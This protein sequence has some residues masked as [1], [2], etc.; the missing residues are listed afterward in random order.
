MNDIWYSLPRIQKIWRNICGSQQRPIDGLSMEEVIWT[1]I[2]F[3]FANYTGQTFMEQ[4]QKVLKKFWNKVLRWPSS[5]SLKVPQIEE[6]NDSHNWSV[7]FSIQRSCRSIIISKPHWNKSGL[8]CTKWRIS[9]LK[10][11]LL[12]RLRWE[13]IAFSEIS[14]SRSLISFQNAKNLFGELL[15]SF[16][17]N[18]EVT[19][20]LFLG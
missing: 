3:T 18:I 6:L 13:A 19:Q 4:L 17:T 16:N 7:I 12:N 1:K 20:S 8:F 14:P 5:I 11:Q 15:S 2:V 9:V 10:V